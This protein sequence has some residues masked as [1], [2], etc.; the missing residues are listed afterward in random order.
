MYLLMFNRSSLV[1]DLLILSDPTR[2]RW[3]RS[4]HA[5][6]HFKRRHLSSSKHHHLDSLAPT[7]VAMVNNGYDV[8][9][10]VD[11]EGDLGHTDLADLE[12]HQSSSVPLILVT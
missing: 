11:D 5:T 10:D 3:S 1:R 2:V 9:V 7:S 12:F 4:R 6:T 8:V